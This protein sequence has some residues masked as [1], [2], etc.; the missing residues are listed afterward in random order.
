MYVYKVRPN[1]AGLFNLNKYLNR[2]NL[3][4]LIIHISVI[5]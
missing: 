4:Y 5:T 1:N 2:L 3:L